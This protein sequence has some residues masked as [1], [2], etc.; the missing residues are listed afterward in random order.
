MAAAPRVLLDEEQVYEGAAEE[1][2]V[3]G[4]KPHEVFVVGNDQESAVAPTALQPPDPLRIITSQRVDALNRGEVVVV[5]E[6]GKRRHV[7]DDRA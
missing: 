6:A 5:R 3:E 4:G 2:V 1:G 7:R